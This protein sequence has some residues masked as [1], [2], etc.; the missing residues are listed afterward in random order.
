[1]PDSNARAPLRTARG[2]RLPRLLVAIPALNEENTIAQVIAAVPRTLPGV[3]RVDVL[4]VNDGSTD[5]TVE[6]TRRAGAEVVHHASTRGVG[7]AFHTALAHGLQRGAD[8]IVTIDGDG[9]FD[10]RDIPAL[11]EPV[12]RQEA[13]FVTASRF[14]DPALTPEMPTLKRWG[15][16]LMSRLISR[17]VGQRFYDVSCGLRCYSRQAAAS[18]NLFGRFTYTQEVFLNLAFKNMN[19]VEVPLRVRG[20]RQFGDSRVAGNLLRYAVNTSRIVFRCYRDYRPLRFFGGLFLALVIPA[21][22]L[23]VFL[24]VHY[25]RTGAL[26]P[27]KWAGFAAAAL[28]MLG[29]LSIHMGLI[30]DMLNRHRV[31]LE[32]LLYHRRVGEA[33]LSPREALEVGEEP[34][35]HASSSTGAS[36]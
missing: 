1:M 13:D 36:R 35:W 23:G 27:H 5:R 16:Y 21:V 7:A 4:V 33:D 10:P 2:R 19:I 3:D 26:S 28:T 31:Y 15:N 29:L 9:Q 24:M 11:I 25:L 6:E 32:E 20:R 12:L 34:A 22:G 14:K 30:G 8:L 17:L 18:L